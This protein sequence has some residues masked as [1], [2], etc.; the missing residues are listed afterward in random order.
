MP[1]RT[2]ARAPREVL[3]RGLALQRARQAAD[4]Q[5]QARR[6]RASRPRRPRGGCRRAP[7]AAGGIAPPGTCR[8]GSSRRARARASRTSLAIVS[9]PTAATWSRHG[10]IAR[11]PCARARLDDPVE[12]ATA[13]RTVAV[14]IDSQRWSAEKS[15]IDR[16]QLDRR[17]APAACFMRRDGELGLLEQAGRVGEA[18]QLGEVRQRARALLA[19]DH[20]EVLLVAVEPGHEHDAGLVEARRRLEDVAR[21]RHRRREDRV[22]ARACRR[23]RV[24]PSAALAAGAIASKMPSSA[25]LCRWLAS[26]ADAVAGDQL[27]VVEVVAGVH[28]HARRAAGGASRS[29]CPCRAARS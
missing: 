8:R 16:A 26:A 5:H 2:S 6:A 21:Q 1:S 23:R 14:L 13:P 20:R 3:V 10:E 11:M 12:R 22:E 28:A 18:E 29:P 25:S 4:H 15:R 27:G 19:A 17:A 24:S 7:P 9:S